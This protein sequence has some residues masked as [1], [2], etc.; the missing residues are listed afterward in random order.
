[1]LDA[2]NADLD[3]LHFIQM[4]LAMHGDQAS[5]IFDLIFSVV[6]VA[7]GWTLQFSNAQQH[8]FRTF[9]KLP[10]V[11]VSLND[12]SVSIAL[13]SVSQISGAATIGPWELLESERRNIYC[14]S[15]RRLLLP[16]SAVHIRT[17]AAAPPCL[18]LFEPCVRSMHAGEMFLLDSRNC[19]SRSRPRFL[20]CI[21]H[22]NTS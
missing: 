15:A 7:M 20:T 6:R 16:M 21:M 19:L 14:N 22:N 13:A 10:H 2:V 17:C 11:Q 3:T 9:Y 1:L 18:F 12:A 4:R 5:R 8:C